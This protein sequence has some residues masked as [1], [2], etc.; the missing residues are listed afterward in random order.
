MKFLAI[1]KGIPNVDWSSLSQLLTEE[2]RHV[3]ELYL[4]DELREIYF[5][6]DRNAVL[7]LES[8]SITSAKALLNGLPLVRDGFIAFDVM[9]LRPYTGFQRMLPNKTA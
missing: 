6:E 3:Y 8:E 9:Q 2:A 5:T 4:N 7:I 1:E